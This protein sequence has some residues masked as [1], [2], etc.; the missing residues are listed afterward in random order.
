[1]RGASDV[2]VQGDEVRCQ[3]CGMTASLSALNRSDV[4]EEELRNLTSLD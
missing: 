1:M 4:T 3:R 2:I